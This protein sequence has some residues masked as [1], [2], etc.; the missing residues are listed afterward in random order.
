[1][2]RDLLK[3]KERIIE[4]I[5]EK[6]KE[7]EKDGFV[8]GLSG[9]I[10]S[11]VTLYLLND[12]V[13]KEKILALILPE[14]DTEPSSIKIAKNLVK[15]LDISYKVIPLTKCLFLLGV[16]QTLPLFLFPFRPLKRK[17]VRRFYE[18]Y[19]KTLL[20]PIFFAQKRRLKERLPFYYEGMAY[21]RIK[22][23]LRMAILYFYAE[24]ENFLVAGC[25]NLTEDIIGYYVRYGDN[26]SDIA[27]ISHLYKTEVRELAKILSIPEEIL[28]RLPSPDL[29]PGIS[30]EFS[31]GIDYET[32]DRILMEIEE[33][34]KREEIEERFGKDFVG[35]VFEQI[36]WVKREKER[37]CRISRF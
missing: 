12:T 33:G 14:L 25:T 35:L 19:S 27:P 2:E 21:Y 7:D 23:R 36:D 30:D 29:L 18:N 6:L 16:Y 15:S 3:E 9:G 8:I 11:A 32:L 24:K 5:K 34:R 17:M 4:F 37:P 26:S 28:N 31:L 10:D 1:M 20:E 13:G 22:H